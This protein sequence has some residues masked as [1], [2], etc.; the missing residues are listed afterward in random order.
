M[1]TSSMMK[2]HGPGVIVPLTDRL[3]DEA[4]SGNLILAWLVA[5]L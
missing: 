3:A 5:N 1:A 2:R 4:A